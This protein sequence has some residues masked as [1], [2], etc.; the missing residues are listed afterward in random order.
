MKKI[1][2]ST[3]FSKN[4]KNAIDY[5]LFLFEKETCTFYLVHGD[6]G[7][8]PKTA[9]K[10]PAAKNLKQ[11][12]KQVQAKNDNPKHQFEMVI[13]TDTVVNLVNRTAINNAVDYIF[14]GAKGYSF[15]KDVFLGSNTV[16]VIKN[17]KYYCPIMVVP[18]AYNF[19]RPEEIIFATD[20]KHGFIETEL[21]GL[22]SISKLYDSL[23]SVLHVQTE[24]QLTKIQKKNK[25]TLSIILKEITYKF[26]DVQM[27]NS[28]TS[29]IHHL[30]KEN[31]K[32]GMV[33]LLN[34]KHGFFQ[35]LLREPILRNMAFQTEVPLLVLQQIAE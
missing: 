4:A 24:K 15:I 5:A 30:E 28:I 6:Q 17:M 26:T 34:T 10:S 20:L 1:I 25:E 12:M 27:V 8:T 23:V 13:E 21:R 11:L 14:M 7:T 35:N 16:D 22:I 19:G 18:E 33:A 29:S 3:D 2:L 9:S 32:I 31:P